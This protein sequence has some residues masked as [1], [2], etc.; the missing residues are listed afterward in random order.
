MRKRVV[1]VYSIDTTDAT[2]CS[3]L[4]SAR[5]QNNDLHKTKNTR[6]ERMVDSMRV[7][8]YEE[9]DMAGG[10]ASNTVNVLRSIFRSEK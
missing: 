10:G 2:T 8:S 4:C 5:Q 3:T 6:L 9:N 1:L 7:S